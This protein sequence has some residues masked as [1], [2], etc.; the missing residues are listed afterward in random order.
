MRHQAFEALFH[1]GNVNPLK[2][3][4]KRNRSECFTPN[5]ATYRSFIAVTLVLLAVTF[6]SFASISTGAALSVVSANTPTFAEKI[7]FKDPI[8]F[9]SYLS[10][11]DSS[12]GIIGFDLQSFAK[13]Q[14]PSA[15]FTA[16]NLVIFR[17]G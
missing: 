13:S 10:I 15:P 16:G 6:L 11:S 4:V 5:E 9:K 7:G 8:S 2:P 14:T 3:V 12:P 17:V 1:P